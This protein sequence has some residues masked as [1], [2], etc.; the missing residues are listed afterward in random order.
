MTEGR[1]GLNILAGDCARNLALSAR[2]E[3]IVRADIHLMQLLEAARGL[4]LPQW[5][6]VAGCIYQT[7]WN[8]LTGRPLGTGI[9]DYDLLYFDGEDLSLETEIA[10]ASRVHSVLHTLTGLVDVSNQ[11]RVHLWFEDYFGIFYPPLSSADEALTRYASTTH[12]VGVRLT[13]DDRLDIFAPFGLDDIFNMIVRPNALPNKATH[14]R[15]AA[16]AQALWS[17]LTVI[18]WDKFRLDGDGGPVR[19]PRFRSALPAFR[20]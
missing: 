13:D 4:H 16:R 19:Q 7:V 1:R 17:E 11:A 3:C 6:V 10:T 2:L 5:R 14:E 15:K 12:A 9:N 8:T 20:G 18:P